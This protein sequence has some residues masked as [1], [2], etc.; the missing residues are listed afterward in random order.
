M[1][2]NITLELGYVSL[3]GARNG[4][5]P[6]ALYIHDELDSGWIP[7]LDALADSFETLAIELPGF[8]A[9]ERPEWAET[10]DDYAY[11]IAD[12]ADSLAADGPLALVGAGLGGWLAVEAA[13][14]GA[15]VDALVAIGAPGVD[16]PGDPPVDYFVLLPHERAP[17]FFDAPADYAPEVDED[18]AIRNESV[19]ARLVWQPRYVNPGL[20]RRLHRVKAPTLTLWGENDRFLSR[21]HGEALARGVVNGEF[22]VVPASGHFPARENPQAASSLTRRFL[23]GALGGGAAE[24]GGG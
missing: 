16:L 23:R 13:V 15:P 6:R 24:S 20:E 4:Q 8:G 11:I 3:K 18:T 14:R 17:L 1:S 21:A 19:T 22:A 9:S 12:V 10:I 2:E 5:G 7:F